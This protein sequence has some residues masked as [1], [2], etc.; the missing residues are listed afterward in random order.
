MIFSFCEG[1]GENNSIV[2]GNIDI[3]KS[4]C[5]VFKGEGEDNV[6]NFGNIKF[7]YYGINKDIYFIF[8]NNIKYIYLQFKV[9]LIF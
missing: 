4:Y 5:G 9:Y 6:F 7:E 8:G 3:R 1:D 2:N